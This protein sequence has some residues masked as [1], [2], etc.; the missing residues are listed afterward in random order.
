MIGPRY[1]ETEKEIQFERWKQKTCFREN[2]LQ[3]H[4]YNALR[5]VLWTLEL[6]LLKI[7]NC[8]GTYHGTK[9]GFLRCQK[10]YSKS[11]KS[12]IIWIWRDSRDIAKFNLL[13][14]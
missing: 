10:N 13:I 2:G 14:L 4:V 7:Q 9:K 12:Q 3:N 6:Q 8:V 11:Q 1:K 5:V